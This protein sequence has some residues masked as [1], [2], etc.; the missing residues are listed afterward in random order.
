M[1]SAVWSY[2]CGEPLPVG[3]PGIETKPLSPGGR[4][5]SARIIE[6]LAGGQ[7]ASARASA[8]AAATAARIPCTGGMLGERSVRASQRQRRESANPSTA[9]APVRSAALRAGRWGCGAPRATDRAAQAAERSLSATGGR[10]G[11]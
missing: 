3:T 5:L 10:G 8:A 7:N 1:Y 9:P 2:R 11:A 6:A 4:E